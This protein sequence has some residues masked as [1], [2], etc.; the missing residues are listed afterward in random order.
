MSILVQK[1]G[2]SS[3]ATLDRVHQVARRVTEAY[4][5]GRPTVVVVSARGDTTDELIRLAREASS[6]R[7]GR[8]LDQLLA[9]GEC[10][11]AALLAIALH[12]MDV[13][14][15]SLTGPQAGLLA[16]GPSGAGVIRAVE[17]GRIRRHLAAG[18][19][20]V[21]AGFQALDPG[22]DLLTLGRGGSDTTAVAL[23]VELGAETCEIWTDVPGVHT[24]DPRVVPSARVLPEVDAPVMAELAFAG[25]RVLHARSVE[26][27]AMERM[28]VRVRS[29]F[30]G[31]GT[32]VVPGR[33]TTELESRGVAVAIAH[34]ADV[35]RVLIHSRGPGA[36]L[37]A[38]VLATFAR[39][40]VPADL[41][42]RSGPYEDEFRMGCTIRR[43]AAPDVRADLERTVRRLD[44]ALV[45]EEN[46]GKVSL[47]GMGLLSRPEYAARLLAAL[48]ANGIT[49]SWIATSQQRISVIV[50][51]DRLVDAVHLL[52][53]EFGLGVP[54]PA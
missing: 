26:L 14:A 53:A 51:L 30:T 6:V 24:A 13:P 25:A 23:A 48:A 5:S 41:I 50:P 36:D 8:E 28:E 7:P 17:T 54:T 3:L 32:V 9:T 18:E 42:A 52:H 44:A 27:A 39:H 33:D 1:Y 40:G 19:V 21:V 12:G 49:T 43:S 15:V 4:R 37:A 22:G 31:D 29:T 2:G 35:A 10:A 45:V 34:D 46:V 38:E 20:V 16:S 47:I 11:S